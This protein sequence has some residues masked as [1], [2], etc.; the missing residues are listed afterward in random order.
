M[1]EYWTVDT[2]LFSIR[3]Q[4]SNVTRKSLWIGISRV[5]GQVVSH[6]EIVGRVRENDVIS[7]GKTKNTVKKLAQEREH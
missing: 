6:V 3:E 4:D 7:S 1:V 2:V 5:S